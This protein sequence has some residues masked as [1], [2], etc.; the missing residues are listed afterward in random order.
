MLA[1]P[2]IDRETFVDILGTAPRDRPDDTQLILVLRHESVPVD[3]VWPRFH[4]R[5]M[6]GKQRAA[7]L[8]NPTLRRH[9]EIRSALLSSASNAPTLVALLEDAEGREQ[10]QLLL[11]LVRAAPVRAATYF[12]ELFRR[13]SLVVRPEFAAI[14]LAAAPQHVRLVLITNMHGIAPGSPTHPT[15]RSA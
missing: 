5:M 8:A 7:V 1:A 11:R 13:S 14:L 3:L 4:H 6:E 9:P 10:E 2:V 15:R 12:A